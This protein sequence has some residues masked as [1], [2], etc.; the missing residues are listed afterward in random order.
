MEDKMFMSKKERIVELE[1]IAEGIDIRI[2][3]CV[4][5]RCAEQ[6][7][8]ITSLRDRISELQDKLDVVNELAGLP[9]IYIYYP[10]PYAFIYDKYCV[11]DALE[12][13]GYKLHKTLYATDG[14]NLREIWIKTK[15]KQKEKH[16][17]A[18]IKPRKRT[19]QA[20]QFDN[21]YHKA[22]RCD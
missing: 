4:K 11:T 5:A 14:S 22:A 2:A 15:P 1:R 20:L 10:K 12:Q 19:R 17:A 9:E 16:E 13:R 3:A 21:P 18:K 8:E 6:Q 7:K